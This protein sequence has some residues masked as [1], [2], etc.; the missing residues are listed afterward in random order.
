[1]IRRFVFAAAI[2]VAPAL[3]A[4]EPF[5]RAMVARI[6]DEGLNRSQVWNILDT[7]ATV[8]GPRLTASPAYMR[9]ATWSRDHFAKWGF[10]DAHFETWPFGRGWELEKFTLEMTAPRYAP[11]IGYPDA[12]SPSTRGDVVGQPIL[13]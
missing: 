10:R 11:L 2:V 4:Q 6:R 1:M 8:I 12:W 13:I 5:D 7:L 9:A 3:A